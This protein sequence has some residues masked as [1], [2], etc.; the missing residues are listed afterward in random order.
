MEIIKFHTM[1]IGE[2]Y[3]TAV[4]IKELVDRGMTS[5][6]SPFVTGTLF[7]GQKL[8]KSQIWNCTV[9]DLAKQ[10][11]I[12][13][14][15]VRVTMFVTANGSGGVY[16]NIKEGSMNVIDDNSVT[17]KDFVHIAPI[18]PDKSFD[19][20]IK[21][22]EKVDSDPK[23]TKSYKSIS[24]LTQKLLLDN[25]EQFKKSSA[26]ERM[27][28]NFLYGL[29]Y[30][31]IRMVSAAYCIC[32]TYKLLDRELLVCATALHDIAKIS[33]YDT[34][35]VGNADMSVQ[36]RLLEHSL[37]GVMMI[38]DEAC[39]EPYNPEKIMMLEHM[40]AS[41]HGKLEW[42]AIMTPAFPEAEVLHLIDMIDS[43]INMFEEA[44][45]DQAPET[46]SAEKVFG[47]EN[48]KIYKP[49]LIEE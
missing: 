49:N 45:L 10:E 11:I 12:P 14:T 2:E 19:W 44:Y 24:H 16:Y 20:L 3:D 23:K 39:K 15:I 43:R 17:V 13:N 26:A 28:H 29:L 5:S 35:E 1:V 34:D 42:G 8:V 37:V 25:K 38:H 33:C 31:T 40:I 32:E 21:I 27:H 41:H 30:H 47:L 48:S 4:L 36:G 46:L 6:G 7:D 9:D 22:I 18:D